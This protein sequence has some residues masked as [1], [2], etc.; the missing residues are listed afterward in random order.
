MTYKIHPS[1]CTCSKCSDNRDNI[2]FTKYIYIYFACI[3]L[4]CCLL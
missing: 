2:M 1:K 4:I 3:V